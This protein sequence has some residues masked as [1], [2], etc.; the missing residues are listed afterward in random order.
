M[1]ADSAADQLASGGGII[2]GSGHDT[3]QQPHQRTAEKGLG[4]KV[5]YAAT[6]DFVAHARLVVGSDQYRRDG[7]AVL[8]YAIHQFEA[9]HRRQVQI[10]DQAVCPFEPMIREGRF[11][12]GERLC[13]EARGAQDAFERATQP[14]I[15]FDKDDDMAVPVD[16]VARSGVG[17]IHPR[18]VREPAVVRI[19]PAGNGCCPLGQSKEEGRT[20]CG[21]A[22]GSAR[23]LR[24]IY[25]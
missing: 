14:R 22:F 24:S 4:E 19:V 6:P 5:L 25:L 3:V 21:P 17:E 18:M 12:T 2:A 8:T 1:Q 16:D 23:G 15:V 9:R 7:D 13:L 11:G 10:H 20:L